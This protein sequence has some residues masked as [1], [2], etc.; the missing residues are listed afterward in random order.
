MS[1]HLEHDSELSRTLYL[2]LK[3]ERNMNAAAQELFIHRNT[4]RYR[5][6]QIDQVINVDL[7]DSDMRMYL[8]FSYLIKD[9]K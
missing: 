5:L 9:R 4:L 3:N 8:L 7:D 2:Y 1:G 6:E